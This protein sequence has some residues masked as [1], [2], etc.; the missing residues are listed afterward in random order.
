MSAGP[1][2]GSLWHDRI[3][4]EL[5]R[6]ILVAQTRAAD[7]TERYAKLTFI[8]ILVTALGAVL[9]AAVTLYK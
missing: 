7:A 4:F 3:K 6:R 8:F 2:P 9:N 5:E 1:Q